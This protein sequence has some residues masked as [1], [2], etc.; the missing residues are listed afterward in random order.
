LSL[1]EYEKAVF[2]RPEFVLGSGRVG[3]VVDKVAWWKIPYPE[4]F[5]FP[6]Q[7]AFL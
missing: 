3:F 5:G 1:Y 2:G 6:C 7:F 4:Y